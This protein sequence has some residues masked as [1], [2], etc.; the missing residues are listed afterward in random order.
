MLNSEMPFSALLNSLVSKYYHANRNL[1]D[2]TEKLGQR[3]SVRNI[4]RYRASKSIPQFATAK[5][6][7]EAAGGNID[8]AD[9]KK[10][11]ELEKAMQKEEEEPIDMI[12]VRITNEKINQKLNQDNFG[13]RDVVKDRAAAIYPDSKNPMEDYICDLIAKDIYED[14]I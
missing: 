4:Q 9:L 13:I 6:L 10:S 7:I 3:I 5:L 11:L 12:Q 2:K 1:S 8:P 14:I